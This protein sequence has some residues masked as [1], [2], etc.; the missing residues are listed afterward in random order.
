MK[1][2]AFVCAVFCFVCV[3][4]VFPVEEVSRETIPI[5]WDESK[6]DMYRYTDTFMREHGYYSVDYAV[7]ENAASVWSTQIITIRY[8]NPDYWVVHEV[9]NYFMISHYFAD[10]QITNNRGQ[11][12]YTISPYERNGGDWLLY[13]RKYNSIVSKLSLLMGGLRDVNA[14]KREK[15]AAYLDAASRV[16][17]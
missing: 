9:H 2:R 13:V 7:K 15:D 6:F 14:T 4:A 16:L 12:E 8:R 10:A 5:N 17:Y 11:V 1:K 3:N